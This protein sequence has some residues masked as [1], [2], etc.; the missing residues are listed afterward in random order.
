MKKTLLILMVALLALSMAFIGIACRQAAAPETT[1]AATVETST[2]A[3]VETTTAAA[4]ETTA[5]AETKPSGEIH[6]GIVM[7]YLEGW[8]SYFDQGFKLVM[9][10]KNVKVTEI[11]TNWEP[12][13]EI[14]A[15]RD[16]IALGVDGI[17]VTSG[18]PDASQTMCQIA[19][20]AGVPIQIVDST[21]SEGTGKP[22]GIVEFD[23]TAVGTM[24]GEKIAENW[25][26]AKVVELQGLAGFGVVESQIKAIKQVEADTG[27]FEVV[28]MEYTDYGIETSKN[29]MRDIIQGGKKF[30]VVIGGA[31]EMAEGAIQALGEAKMLDD[32]IVISGNG[33]VLD[34]A[35]FEAGKLDA[36]ISQ[37]VGF[38]GILSAISILEYLQ[39]KPPLALV[40]TPI[41][42]STVDDW[43][44]TL[45]PWNVD[46][47]WIPVAEEF[48]KTGVLNY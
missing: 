4:V 12:E 37:P 45:I 42:W 25:S 1:A 14:Q 33:G 47:S 5:A 8:F 32:V 20:E 7:P 11:L 3:S 19:N 6:I 21:V 2:T 38:H 41:V 17:S 26:G 31:Q 35:N 43:K 28:Q 39:G 18:N 40:S 34:E 30:N 16:L 27:A 46:A 48:I 36:A 24:F 44:E 15:V 22:F 13:K 29:L 23:W 10:K 9:A